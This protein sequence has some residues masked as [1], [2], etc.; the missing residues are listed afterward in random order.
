MVA[1]KPIN[2]EIVAEEIK[3]SESKIPVIA[4]SPLIGYQCSWADHHIS[5]HEPEQ[6]LT[7]MRKLLG[8]PR[9][10]DAARDLS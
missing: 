4:L 7:L 5:S 6:L 8:D 3:N 1:E 10:V 2:C 9:E